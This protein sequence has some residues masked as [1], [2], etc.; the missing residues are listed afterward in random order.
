MLIM[1][2]TVEEINLIAIY[3]AD[4]KSATLTGIISALPHMASDMLH[5][6]AC[7]GRKVNALTDDEFSSMSFIA[8]TDEG[9]EDV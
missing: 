5:I 9:D 7:A 2:F 3:K 6:A 4:T 8:A 1:D